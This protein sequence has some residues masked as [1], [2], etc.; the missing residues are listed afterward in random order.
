MLSAQAFKAWVNAVAATHNAQLL[1]EAKATA[2]ASGELTRRMVRAGNVSKLTQAQSQ[3]LLS[4]AAL[5]L[6]R[7]ETAALRALTY[8]TL[9]RTPATP[10]DGSIVRLTFAPVPGLV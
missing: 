2:E 5:A 9:F 7:A 8:Q 6:V 1:R 3:A 10:F 4:D